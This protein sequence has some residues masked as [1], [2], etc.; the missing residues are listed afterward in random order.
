M[1]LL[2]AAS[3]VLIAGSL[4]IAPSAAWADTAAEVVAG[5]GTQGSSGDGGPAA[6]AALSGPAGVAAGA[7]GTIFI[8]DAGNHVVRAVAPNGTISTVAGNGQAGGPGAAVPP[9]AVAKDVALGSPNTLTVART[10]RSTSSTSGNAG[11][12]R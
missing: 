10:A 5:T 9:D 6:A 4:S 3:A 7:D 11:S 1:P 2:G 8:S 12:T